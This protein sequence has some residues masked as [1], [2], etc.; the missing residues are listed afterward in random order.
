MS[1]LITF[2]YI[3]LRIACVAVNS[4]KELICT[5]LQ[6]GSHTVFLQGKGR[7]GQVSRECLL[8]FPTKWQLLYLGPA[9]GIAG[10]HLGLSHH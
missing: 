8:N 1:E 2:T 7:Q 10:L 4:I 6:G 9:D 3:V 5:D